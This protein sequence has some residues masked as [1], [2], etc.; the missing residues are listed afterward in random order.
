MHFAFLDKG[1]YII[2]Q[3]VMCLLSAEV[4]TK[5]VSAGAYVIN[6]FFAWLILTQYY[7]VKRFKSVDV[8][9]EE[10][11]YQTKESGAAMN[12]WRNIIVWP[13]KMVRHPYNTI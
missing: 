3:S 12:I 4:T 13:R 1:A 10:I 5:M 2:L 7:S 11:Q 9:D 8:F 6:Q